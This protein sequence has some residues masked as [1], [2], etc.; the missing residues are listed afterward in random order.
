L[1][2]K[3]ST[4]Q[5]TISAVK[6]VP[7]LHSVFEVATESGNTYRLKK[8]VD[9]QNFLL[10]GFYDVHAASAKAGDTIEVSK[11]DESGRSG[12]AR[13]RMKGNEISGPKTE[14]FKLSSG[15]EISQ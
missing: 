13:I 4:I 8:N 10:T 15:P 1:E 9:M 14:L 2:E 6:S 12:H 7:G 11:T 5:E 3:L